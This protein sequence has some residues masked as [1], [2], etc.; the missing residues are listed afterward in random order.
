MFSPDRKK[1][2]VGQMVVGGEFR[3]EGRT[4]RRWKGFMTNRERARL[5]VRT[6]ESRVKAQYPMLEKALVEELLRFLTR[7]K[8][9]DRQ[10]MRIRATISRP[11]CLNS[12]CL[13]CAF[14]GPSCTHT[15]TYMHSTSKFSGNK[16]PLTNLA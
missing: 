14:S 11:F 15:H 10:I 12:P 8:K 16:I 5:V 1:M 2:S 9:K 3:N 13:Y 7:K 4:Q 6:R